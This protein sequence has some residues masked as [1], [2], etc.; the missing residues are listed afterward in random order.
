MASVSVS[1]MSHDQLMQVQRS[2][3]IYQERYEDALAPWNIRAPAPVLGQDPGDYRR[4]LAV[5]AKKLLPDG[6]KFRNAQYR[7]LDES[8][9][10]AMEPQ[11]LEAVKKEARNPNT[12]VPGQFRL[13]PEIDPQNGLKINTFV[14]PE[15]FIKQFARSGRRV[16]CFNTSNGRVDASGRPLR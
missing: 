16:L 15:S 9:M 7:R 4:D 8:A 10:N 3:R 6:H 12:V 1:A 2:A 5:R 11:L 14:G 13:V